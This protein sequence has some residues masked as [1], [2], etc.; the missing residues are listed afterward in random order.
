[1]SAV[2]NLVSILDV[3]CFVFLKDIDSPMNHIIGQTYSLGNDSD[4]ISLDDYTPM[5]SLYFQL[6]FSM[7]TLL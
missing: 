2:T 4:S 3:F 1:M 7:E 6:L 5:V